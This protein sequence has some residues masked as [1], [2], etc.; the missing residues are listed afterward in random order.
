MADKSV[1][2]VDSGGTFTDLV[3]VDA[4]AGT[5]YVTKTP[6]TPADPSLGI[7]EGTRLM[8]EQHGLSLAEV[9]N[10]IHATTLI[11]N[12]I[13]ERKGAR[14]GL[15]TT[16]GFKDILELRNEQ[17]YDVYDLFLSYPDPIVPRY[18]RHEVTER[19]AGSG[20]PVT[21][22]SPEDIAAAVEH[23][24]A[25]GVE[26]VAI[27]FLHSYANAAHERQARDVVAELWPDVAAICLS[28]EVMPEIGEYERFS[29]TTTNAYVQPLAQRYLRDTQQRLAD[30][31]FVGSF[32]V[33]LS[34]AGIVSAD[35]AGRFP[36]RVVE[37]GPAAG[38][39]CAAR[40][41]RDVGLDDLIAFDMGGTTAKISVIDRGVPAMSPGFEV[42]RVH[43]FKR[44]S[45][46]PLRVPSV[47]ILEIGAGGGSIASIDPTG[48]L[49]VGPH[50][51]SADPGPACYR[52]GGTK[53][54]VTD[55][56]LV[57]GLLEPG[58]FLG[59]DMALDLAASEA[60]IERGV[61][62]PLGLSVVEAAWGIHTMVN[63]NMIGALRVHLAERGKDPEL[64]TLM[65]FGGCGPAHAVEVASALRVPEVLI[66]LGAGV[67]SALGAALA[68]PAFDFA[69]SHVRDLGTMDWDAL[70]DVYAQMQADAK[71]LLGEAGV[72]PED[73]EFSVSADMRYE[74]Q[75]Y[76]IEVPLPTGLSHASEA[77]IR[78][79]FADEYTQRYA[80]IYPE[81]EIQ[82]TTCRLRATG[83]AADIDLRTLYGARSFAASTEEAV[84]GHRRIYE[85]AGAGWVE[86]PVYDRYALAPGAAISGPAVVEEREST[87]ILW[88]G[89]T[90][91]IDE[92]L[93]LTIRTGGVHG[94]GDGLAETVAGG[95]A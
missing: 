11:T 90:G 23:F 31:G 46:I 27:A 54:T 25:E 75:V 83:P 55:A 24:K 6:T 43:R 32:F 28:S 59:G 78:E 41:G 82:L 94:S 52:R 12:A 44:G 58:F 2:G 93:N 45:G 80:R 66:P 22:V 3:A 19:M 72:S 34:N 26:A 30:H 71:A 38:V 62:G 48:L 73:V 70:Q 65:G 35:V 20:E 84:K 50:S 56:N 85:G 8:N 40:Y 42:A 87:A 69:R 33:M 1:L 4:A 37:S 47:D 13:V 29:V 16:R 76:D 53:P 51:A 88:S 15:L 7:V 86:A 39:L 5:V 68:P 79:R 67:A 60:V 10:L 36:V 81:S 57:L 77:T 91:A 74:G 21:P 64:Y 92:F 9:G 63:Q 14:V 89:N 61:A 17:R 18:L 95:E 49:Q